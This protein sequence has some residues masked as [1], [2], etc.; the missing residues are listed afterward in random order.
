MN[1]E[2]LDKIIDERLDGRKARV[3]E[4]FDDESIID[5]GNKRRKRF[6]EKL[7][8]A[9]IAVIEEKVMPR[10]G[11]SI[12]SVLKSSWTLTPDRHNT[13]NVIFQ[14]PS[15]FESNDNMYLL[16][17][18]LLEFGSRGGAIPTEK[19][20]LSTLVEKALP[21]INIQSP[22]VMVLKPERT[23]WEK[24]LTFCTSVL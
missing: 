11:E 9:T 22:T 14:Y 15:C 19:I 23:F 7:Q 21:S 10:L 16:P 18:I 24:V 20:V 12:A 5:L 3:I 17:N 8:V 13:Q 1:Q 4:L 2:Y 6:F